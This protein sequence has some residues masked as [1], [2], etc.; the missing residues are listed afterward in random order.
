MFARGL[1]QGLAQDAR[2]DARASSLRV[3]L[4]TPHPLG[5]QQ[6]GIPAPVDRACVVTARVERDPKTV[7]GGEDDGRDDV[8]G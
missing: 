8:G 7:L 2:L 6:Q 3:D 4:D 5:L 1:G